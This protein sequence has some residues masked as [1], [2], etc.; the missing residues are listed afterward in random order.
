MIHFS[1]LLVTF[2]CESASD[3]SVKADM[4]GRDK[5]LGTWCRPSQPSSAG[6][7]VG[8]CWFWRG[9]DIS[10]N[11]S[12]LPVGLWTWIVQKPR[13]LAWKA[14]EKDADTG[15]R[16]TRV[17]QQRSVCFVIKGFGIIHRC[18]GRGPG[19]PQVLSCGEDGGGQPRGRDATCGPHEGQS[20]SVSQPYSPDLQVCFF[21]FS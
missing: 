15:Q 19:R 10:K 9:L 18:L 6:F 7:Q 16:K 20:C 13:F 21:F 1:L 5:G 8:E 2:K 4:L 11:P 17:D 12:A 14:E 3:P